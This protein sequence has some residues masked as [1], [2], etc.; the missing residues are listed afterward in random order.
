MINLT[1]PRAGR[2][3]QRGRRVG[4]ETAEKVSEGWR[5]GGAKGGISLK[6][7]VERKDDEKLCP[8]NSAL[9]LFP[10]CD[11]L[12]CPSGFTPTSF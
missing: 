2:G 7:R 3:R 9:R 6:E 10:R 8:A 4:A 11:I 5:C 1:K 12:N